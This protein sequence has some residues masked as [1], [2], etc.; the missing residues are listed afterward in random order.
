MLKRPLLILL[1]LLVLVAWPVAAQTGDAGTLKLSSSERRQRMAKLDEPHREFLRLATP[2]M[3]EAELD[4]F[5]LLDDDRRDEAISKFW[6][7]RAGRESGDQW[8]SDYEARFGEAKQF[9]ESLDSHRAQIY[10]LRGRPS[11][12]TPVPCP[13]FFRPIEVWSYESLPS[14]K[15]P[16]SLVFYREEESS[17]FTLLTPEEDERRT[18]GEKLLSSKGA[19]MGPVPI[20]LGIPETASALPRPLALDCP[21]GRELLAGIELVRESPE[22]I[23]NLLDRSRNPRPRGEAPER[24]AIKSSGSNLVPLRARVSYPGKRGGRTVTSINLEVDP[25]E[26]TTTSRKDRNFH[27]LRLRGEVTDGRSVVDRFRYD[28]EV[29]PR[30]GENLDLTIERFL[31]PYDYEL[32][33]HLE[34]RGS[35]AEG[36][37]SLPIEVPYIDPMERRGGGEQ[38]SAIVAE[39]EQ[40]FRSGESSIRIVPLGSGFFIGRQ[41]FDTLLTGKEI[42]T[43]DFHVGERKVMSKRAAPFSIELDLG[44]IPTPRTI[45]V[46]GRDR[47]GR[48]VAGDE[49]LVNGGSDP[50][51]VRIVSPRISEGL[52]GRIRV[53]VTAQVPANHQLETLE[54]YVNDDRVAI[55]YDSPLVQI[56]EIPSAS[57]TTYIRA[58]ATINDELGSHT[59]DVVLLNAPKM[60]EEVDVRLVELPTTVTRKREA[61][62][63]LGAEDFEVYDEGERVEIQKLEYVRDLPLSIGMAIDSSG[64]MRPRMAQALRTGARFFQSV[65]KPGD[66]AFLLAFSDEPKLIQE[67]TDSLAS[68][69][70]GLA[71]LDA[72]EMTA[73]HDAVIASLYNFQGLRGQKALVLLSDGQDTASGF[74]FEQVLEYARRGGIPIYTIGLGIRR[75]DVETRSK[76]IKLADQ[77]GAESYFIEGPGGLGGIYDEIELELR[78]QYILGFY[79]SLEARESGE[80]RRIRVEVDGASAKTVRGYY[81]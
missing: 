10:L 73:L 54:L 70:A 69:A 34:D 11:A 36:L 24:L 63:D 74:T 62:T 52:S 61:V 77:T 28:L 37:V 41:R 68:L 7:G 39:M 38:R 26:L 79:P 35:D 47:E 30:D 60:L 66:R 80:W 6:A 29:P 14:L 43:V 76:L 20:I 75:N 27:D 17:P 48:I 23:T 21:G 55:G 46:V 31:P 9:F 32:T 78:S 16:V 44:D 57:R 8:R 59:E 15:G 4:A 40:Q 13:D 58:V 53:E 18:L 22:R 81:P 33:L 50:F 71:S 51:R 49:L 5:L 72:A 12:M 25:K 19:R 64:S 42:E 56:V 1:S 67:W 45:R 3:T 65:L 2:I